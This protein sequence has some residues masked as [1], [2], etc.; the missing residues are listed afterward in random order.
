[1]EGCAMAWL[2]AAAGV[3]MATAALGA[4]AMSLHAQDLM[5]WVRTSADHQSLPFAIVDKKSAEMHV[6]D[7]RGRLVAS[8]PV[9]LGATVGDHSVPGV[10]ERAQRGA[11]RPDE[12]TTPAGRFVS[13]AGENHTGEHVVWVD[14]ESAFAIHRLRPG[15]AFKARVERLGLPG[16]DG[17][18]VSEGCVVAPVA[19]YENVVQR[20]LGAG[21]SIV[22]VMP[23]SADMR[24]IFRGV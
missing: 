8:S 11:V 16:A 18:R 14:Y 15:R 4:S 19:F 23:E 12:R 3:L 24:D 17:K 6:F 20:V 10:G 21:R 1:M 13:H 2:R 5:R 9:L 22:Y 7:A